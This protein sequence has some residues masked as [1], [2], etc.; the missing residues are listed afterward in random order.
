MK[1]AGGFDSDCG[2]FHFGK[3]AK[4]RTIMTKSVK[5]ALTPSVRISKA[6]PAFSVKLAVALEK[7]EEDQYLILTVK[8]S[9]RYVQFAAQGSFGLR[10]ETT[11]NSYLAKLEKLNKKQITALIDL[12]WSAPT[13]SPSKATQSNDPDGSPN[14]FV[15]FS[16]PF[17]SKKVAELAVK[18]LTGVLRVPHP[19][20]LQYQAFDYQGEE[21]ALPE[22]GLKLEKQA[23]HETDSTKVADLLL[24]TL[25]EFT[26]INDFGY[27]AD[28]DIGIS[29][30]STL[31]L[32]RLI[33]GGQYLRIFSPLVHEVEDDFDI[34]TQ[35]NDINASQLQIRYFYR[36]GTIYANSDIA[37]SPYVS[38]FVLKAFNH[39]C[40]NVDGVG[41]I[42]QN[43]FGGSIVFP[44]SVPSETKH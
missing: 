9:N 11:S 38:E 16:T 30:G 6:W 35:L 22:L 37:V 31:I 2:P 3:T 33:E 32:L 17:S 40:L 20:S 15:E 26:G 25:K 36:N 13:G 43:E 1:T 24:E 8:N 10:A 14:F 39:F 29:Y 28:G 4:R 27:D 34:C 41:G 21:I 23:A 7:L 44:E 5:D 18:T 42:L 19:G 12:G